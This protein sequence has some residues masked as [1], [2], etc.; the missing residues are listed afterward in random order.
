M[1]SLEV[2]ISAADIEITLASM[3]VYCKYTAVVSETDTCE[4]STVA[5]FRLRL[6]FKIS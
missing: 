6:T 5:K 3:I 4:K 1:R 2:G